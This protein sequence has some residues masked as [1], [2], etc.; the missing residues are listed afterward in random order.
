MFGLLAEKLIE[1]A[2]IGTA[3]GIPARG[4][5]QRQ[6]VKRVERDD[7][8]EAIVIALRRMDRF[9]AAHFFSGL[10]HEAERPLQAVLLHGRLGSEDPGE[11]AYAESR[12]R[13]GMSAGKAGQAMTR[14]AVSRCLLA[15]ARNRVVFGIGHYSWTGARV[16]SRG[17][18]G[19]HAARPL[20]DGKTFRFQLRYIPFA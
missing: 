10:A 7:R 18:G 8:V 16:P 14:C 11:R 3:M 9:R 2:V 1:E 12:V 15:V 17:E 20:L 4:V 19:R 13:I 6:H 5:A